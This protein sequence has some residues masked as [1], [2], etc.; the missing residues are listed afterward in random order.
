MHMRVNSTLASLA[1]PAQEVV[2]ALRQGSRYEPPSEPRLLRALQQQVDYLGLTAPSVS[3]MCVELIA[4]GTVGA[5]CVLVCGWHQVMSL[6]SLHAKTR[7][8][9]AAVSQCQLYSCS[10][11]TA[12]NVL[13]SARCCFPPPCSY[14]A[15]AAGVQQPGGCAAALILVSFAQ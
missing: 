12:A 1:R 11:L 7:P 4:A 5:H 9:Q 6:S 2:A 3:D 14:P 8:R 13:L 10:V 15:G